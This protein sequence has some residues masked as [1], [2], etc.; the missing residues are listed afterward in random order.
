MCAHCAEAPRAQILLEEFVDGPNLEVFLGR[1]SGRQ[2]LPAFPPFLPYES[3]ADIS[4]QY[5]PDA[6][7]SRAPYEP[8][9]HLSPSLVLARRSSAALNGPPSADAPD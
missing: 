2:V 4:S 8:D 7:L 3:D 5:K 6:H 9:A 1:R